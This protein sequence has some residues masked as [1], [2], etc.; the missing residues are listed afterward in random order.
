MNTDRMSC[1]E[2]LEWIPLYVGG[3]LDTE[4]LEAVGTHLALCEG[5]ARRAGEA[6]RARRALVA[7]FRARA[8]D[9]LQPDLWPGIRAT[10]RSEGLIHEEPAL[11]TLAGARAPR[12]FRLLRTLVPVAAAASLFALLQLGG[13]LRSA[14]S[15]EAPDRVRP[16]IGAPEV[17]PGVVVTPVGTGLRRV[18]GEDVEQLIP[19]RRPRSHPVGQGFSTDPSLAGLRDLR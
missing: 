3:D 1:A 2:V 14:P 17:A 16:Y 11:R 15:P 12:R 19:H 9:T 4:A 18:A 8:A 13:W 7:A 6:A 5:C 10:L